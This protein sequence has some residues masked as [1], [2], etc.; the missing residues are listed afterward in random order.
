VFSRARHER[1]RESDLLRPVFE[2]VVE[3]CIAARLVGG[4]GF[5]VDASLIVADANKQRSVRGTRWNRAIDPQTASRATKEISPHSM[6]L[7][8]GRQAKSFRSLCR[9]PI[10]RRNGPAPC[11]ARPSSA[12]RTHIPVNDKSQRE[13]GTFSR[14]DFTFDTERNV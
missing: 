4:E 3:S 8:S 9:H 2:R 13:D 14:E 7:P 1:F 11:G 6:T 12:T 10:P 5:A